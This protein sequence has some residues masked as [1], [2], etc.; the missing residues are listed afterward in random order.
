ML[1]LVTSGCSFSD[2]LGPHKR[3]P[4]HVAD[5]LGA[6]LY[7]FGVG[8]AGNDHI[9]SSAVFQANKLLGAGVAAKDIR[10]I[11]MWTGMKRRGHFISQ[12]DTPGFDHLTNDDPTLPANFL[13]MQEADGDGRFSVPPTKQSG[14]LFGG[15]ACEFDNTEIMKYK[16]LYFDNFYSQEDSVIA[17]LNHFLHLQWFCDAR[18]IY[19]RNMTSEGLFGFPAYPN[20]EHLMGMLDFSRWIFWKERLGIFEYARDNG[21]PLDVDGWHPLPVGH[22]HFVKNYLADRL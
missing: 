12:A 20:I 16:K 4:H 19:L 17:A 8:S 3:W 18:G 7:N 2:N 1:H 6:R 11:V 13:H 22:E 9:A 5:A 14:W 15:P 10:V 21:L